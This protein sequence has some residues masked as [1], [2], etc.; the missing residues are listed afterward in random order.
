MDGKVTDLSFEALIADLAKR[1]HGVVS[2]RQLLDLGM[3]RTAVD[4]RLARGSLHQVYRGV[5]VVGYRR[6]SRK[7]RW[8]AA[9]LA[10]GPGA[11]LSHGAAGCLW[12]FLSPGFD[13]IEVTCPVG[14]RTRRAGIKCHEAN[15]AADEITEIDGIPVTSVFRTL[16]DLAGD[17]KP[18]Q[19]ERAWKEVKVKRLTDRVPMAELIDRHPTKRGAVA[20]RG[21]LVSTRPIQV[22][23]NEFEERFLV[24]L[25]ASDLPQ[26]RFNAP[27][28][29]RGQFFEPDCL[30]EDQKLI[31]ELDG[32]EVHNTDHAF[33]SDR[34]RDRILLAEGYR[35]TRITWEQLRD[36]PEEVVADLRDALKPG[37]FPH[38]PGK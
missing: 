38:P 10:C 1:Q 16:F 21:L 31:A 9:V 12:G 25:D 20:L 32:G 27:L 24:V 15:L 17:L 28:H 5:Y 8:M 11:V 33:Q 26:P 37:Q 2:R 3:G 36:E 23:R 35:T 6:I 22:T 7:G 4:G 14:R 34:K 18:R 30:W 29:L 13:R 19:F